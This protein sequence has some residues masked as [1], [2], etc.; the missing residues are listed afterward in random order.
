MSPANRPRARQQ[1]AAAEARTDI[2]ESERSRLL[3]AATEVMQRN[4]WWGFKVDSVLRQAGLST[5]SFYRH[6]HK[7]SDLLV[8]LFEDELGASAISLRRA[9]AAVETPSEKVRA[10]IAAALD[11]A[12]QKDLAKPLSLVASHW[13]EML[14]E[15]PDAFERCIAEVMAP[16]VEAIQ[17]GIATG[18]FTSED[19]EADAVAVFYLVA[20][21]TA[22]QASLGG[23]TPR[24]Q[25]EHV[26]MP[27]IQRAIGLQ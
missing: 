1:P 6:F 26:L 25:L 18:E 21:M 11:A 24:E 20:G 2:A 12:Y 10:Y 4:G 14:L 19:P 17:A 13:R 16:L 27:F 7:K 3:T 15:N 22:D 23:T 5:R 8:A 9:T